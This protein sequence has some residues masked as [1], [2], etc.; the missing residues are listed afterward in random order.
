MKNLIFI[1]TLL[2]IIS[3]ESNITS[4]KIIADGDD[5]IQYA[6]GKLVDQ[7]E[8]SG[9]SVRDD[10]K[11][12]IKLTKVEN[13]IIQEEG[14]SV[15][16]SN[17]QI[18]VSGIDPEGVMYGTLDLAENIRN[19]ND[20]SKIESYHINPE[21][22]F[23]AIKFNLPWDSYRRSPA[24]Q[25]H[26]ETVR[27]INYWKGFLDMM[28]ENKFNT[29]TLW[30]LHPYSWMIRPV[31]YPDACPFNDEQLKEWQQFW[32]SLFGMAKERGIETYI[33][34]WNI[35]V[36]EEFAENYNAATYSI[37]ET[38]FTEGD[39]SALVKNYNKECV[40]QVLNEYPA[41]TG[42]GISLGEGMG[43]MTP[44]QREQWAIESLIAGV[45]AAD[46]PAKL[47]H[48]VPFSANLGSGG[49]TNLET[50]QMTRITLDS[51]AGKI[52]P[53]VWV[54]VKFNWSHGH[55]SPSL[56]KVHGGPIKDTYWN[57]EPSNYKITWMIRNEDFFCLRW[58][59][60]DFIKAHISQN[61]HSYV[62]G[63]FVGSEC[64][65]PAVDYF[66]KINEPVNWRYAY[67]R[68][69]LFYK[70]WGNLLF[71]PDTD[72]TVFVNEF[73]NRYPDAPGEDLYEAYQIAS[74]TPLTIASFWNGTWDFTLY[75]E[76]LLAHQQGN[77]RFI[78][79]DDLINVDP[80]DSKLMSV[81]E[82]AE[83]KAI[84]D[85]VS[86]LELADS[87]QKGSEKAL[88]LIE[89]IKTDN[90]PSLMYEVADIEIWSNM[91]LYLA[92]KL[93]GAV[94]LAQ[95]RKT[96]TPEQQNNAINHLENA[97][98]YWDQVINI[99]E[100]IYKVMPLVHLSNNDDEYFH[101]S[102]YKVAVDNDIK[103]ASS[104]VF[105]KQ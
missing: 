105:A 50:E 42:I 68:Q 71:N 48:R 49:S 61:H 45:Q 38:Y 14:F 26:F 1:F 101:W 40:T 93:R 82:Y 104:A 3:C 73:Y 25:M 24:L 20:I 29:L 35:F 13:D 95:F 15:D 75:S 21:V 12:T 51:L 17:D 33:V 94:A 102:K 97:S 46:R 31:N 6:K 41:L 89:N 54:E 76:G 30:N 47:I 36:S 91:A 77:T 98:K 16:V 66:T 55:S 70:T 23:R 28:A 2:V 96:G 85:R 11:Y 92:E 83:S 56:V 80:L 103:I 78:T 53:P 67:E 62:G 34:N 9:Y 37:G 79:V 5:Q 100:P 32:H 87:L 60:A 39:T 57:P 99:S 64:Y 81:S 8:K 22:N 63:Y 43:G 84:E 72:K 88:A 27:D 65:I 74:R 86:P 19:K 52:E 69:W 90:N 4:V 7:L 58:G 18:M 44:A 10:G 59:S